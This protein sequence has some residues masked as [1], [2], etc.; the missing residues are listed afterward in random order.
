MAAGH[1]VVPEGA[2]GGPKAFQGQ[3]F[4]LRLAQRL[5][6]AHRR[7]D[8]LPEPVRIPLIRRLL[9]VTEGV[10]RDPLKASERLDRML[11]ELSEQAPDPPTR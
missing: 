7:A 11:A 3:E 4:Y 9:T 8:S 2:D 1:P 6:E 5:K 10:K